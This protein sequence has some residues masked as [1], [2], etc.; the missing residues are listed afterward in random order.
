MTSVNKITAKNVM[1]ENPTTLTKDKSLTQIKNVMEEKDIRTV[2]VLDDGILIGAI[3]YRDLIRFIQFNPE[4]TDVKKVMHQPPEFDKEDSLVDLADLRI[5]SGRKM[6]VT[7]SGN[8]LEGVVTDREFVE[9]FQNSDELSKILTESLATNNLLTVFQEDSVEKARHKML[10]NNVSRLP[11][12]DKNGELTGML[13]STHVL[14]TMVKR[15]R[16]ES[17]GRSGARTGEEVNISGGHEKESMSKIPAKN[18]MERNLLTLEDHIDADKAAEKM[19]EGSEEEIIFVNGKYPES[20]LAVKDLV[21]YIAEFAPGKT[22][23][24][25][26]TGIDTSEEKAAVHGKIRKQLQGSIGRK[27]ERAEELRMRVKKMDSDGKKHRYEIDTRLDCNYGLI[28]I[29]EEGW[30]LLDVVDNSLNQLNT[31]LRKKK[32]KK[33]DH[34]T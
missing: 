3:G 16:V 20:I 12:L 27:I 8:S 30:D 1:N 2:P 7:K 9:A 14:K 22:I 11:V 10:D 19:I 32:E 18:L 24:V 4:K 29:E 5:N 6:L 34:R 23:L 25:S 21:D 15:E 33:T 13:K 26:L 28:K 31:V 17:G